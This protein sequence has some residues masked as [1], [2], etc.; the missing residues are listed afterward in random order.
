MTASILVWDREVAPPARADETL[1]WRSYEGQDH[2]SIPRYLEANAGRIRSRYLA[3][4][5]DLGQTRVGGK[6]VVEQLALADGFSLWWMTP[7]AEKNPFKSPRLYSCLRLLA[8]EEILR[9]RKPAEVVLDGDD[10]VLAFAM[11][12]L[13][14]HLGI[15]FRRQPSS[16]PKDSRSPG[17]FYRRLPAFA[18]GALFFARHIANRR[19]FRRAEKTVWF[20]G[21]DAVFFCSYFAYLDSASCADGVFRSR[22]WGPLPATLRES[23]RHSN[24]LHHFVPDADVSDPR[25]ALDW[26]ARFNVDAEKQGAHAFLDTYLTWGV[27]ARALKLWLGLGAASWRL[28]GLEAGPEAAAWLWP[29]L[30]EDWKNSLSGSVAA[31]NCLWVE[32]FDAALKDVPPQR[33]GLYLCENLGWERA[34]LRA[35][36][37]HGHGRVIGVTHTTAPYWHLYFLDDPRTLRT[38]GP[39]AMPQPDLV[40]ANGPAARATFLDAGFPAERLIDLEALRYLGVT[41]APRKFDPSRTRVLVLGDSSPALTAS[42]L[43]MLAAS[44]PHLPA[45][46]MFAFKPHPLFTNETPELD[47]L[48]NIERTN[49]TLG[50]LLDKND[51]VLAANSTSG[52]VDAYQAG[53]PVIVGLDG[54]ELNLSPL[55]GVPGVRFAGTGKELTAAFLA[56]AQN[57]A[58]DA[59][60]EFFFRDPALPRWRRLLS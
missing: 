11:E 21:R 40:A 28:R 34:F 59:R 42:L 36:R 6:T 3:F 17:R 50:F 10:D 49:E 18:R 58:A 54:I 27:A 25:V 8:L 46:W 39:F 16:S 30:R 5:H 57:P 33:E 15:V 26:A 2:L 23:G 52:S 60:V 32:L 14:L 43:T 29:L 9:D 47:A 53:L 12:A 37:R 24:W 1:S 56:A 35:W 31:A 41:A 48:E 44:M 13:C 38:A 20:S 55:R 4:I 51:L 45:G 7:I 19:I 22:Q